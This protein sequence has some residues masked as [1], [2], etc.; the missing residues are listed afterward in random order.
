MNDTE[1]VWLVFGTLIVCGIALSTLIGIVL[2][3]HF[4]RNDDDR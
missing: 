3:N 1:A 4:D 2:S